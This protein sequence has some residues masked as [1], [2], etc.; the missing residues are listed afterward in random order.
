M[1]RKGLPMG[2]HWQYLQKCTPSAPIYLT[3]TSPQRPNKC[4]GFRKSGGD[5]RS[6]SSSVLAIGRLARVLPIKKI[7]HR[8]EVIL[9]R[10]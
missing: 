6:F 5:M 9:I 2:R 7:R 10:R 1:V 4:G 8:N 3:L